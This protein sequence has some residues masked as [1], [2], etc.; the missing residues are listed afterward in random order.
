LL[1]QLLTTDIRALLDQVKIAVEEVVQETCKDQAVATPALQERAVVVVK[2]LLQ[3][4]AATAA[5]EK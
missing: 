4:T 1:P 2:V 5:M 3:I